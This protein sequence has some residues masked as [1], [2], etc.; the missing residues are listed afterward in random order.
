MLVSLNWLS[1]FCELPTPSQL[2][3]DFNR[4]GFEI[5]SDET[6][7]KG[8]T[9][10][11]V[12]HIL[13]FKNHPDADRLRI[14]SVDIGTDTVQIVTAA[15]NVNTGDKIPVSLPGA[16]LANGMK[17]KKGKLRG[18]ESNGM[19]CSAVECGLTDTSPGVWVLPENTPVGV[20]FIKEA[21]L[22]DTILDIAILPNRGDALS[23]IGLARECQALYGTNKAVKFDPKYSSKGKQSS[24]TCQV[25]QTICSYYRAQK[26]SG[27]LNKTTP[28]QYQTRLYYSG[29]KP[30]TW[31]VDVTNIVMIE[32]GQPLH[33]FDA[34]GVN[35][36]NVTKANNE[37]V[38]LLNEKEYKLSPNVSVVKVNQSIAAIAGIM[39]ARQYEVSEL[40]TAI[41]L[42][43]AIFDAV[44]VRQGTKALGVRSESSARFEK[45][46]DPSGL[47]LA[48]ARVLQLLSMH[49]NIEINQEIVVGQPL[50]LSAQIDVDIVKLNQFLG[51]NYGFSDLKKQ[52]TPLGFKVNKAQVTVPSWRA[53]DCQEWPDIAEEMCRFSGIEDI[54]PKAIESNIEINHDDVWIKR[55]QFQTAAIH[56]GLTEVIPFPLNEKDRIPNQPLILNPI[57]PELTELRS[58]A[59]SSLLNIAAVN[60][61]R[62]QRPCRLFTIGPAWDQKGTEYCH[63]SALLQGSSHFEPHLETHKTSVDF[64]QMKGIL[65]Q[66]LGGVKYDL[67]ASTEEILH[68]G[69]SADMIIKGTKVGFFGMLHPTLQKQQRIDKSAVLEFNVS[70]VPMEIRNYDL[71][72]KFPATTRDVTYI[73]PADQQV[74]DIIDILFANKPTICDSIV[75]CGYYKKDTEVNVSFRMIYQSPERSLEMAEV[76]QTHQTFAEAVIKKLPC[77]FP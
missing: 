25:D 1:E 62:H 68:P 27:V 67:V 6:K 48:V 44:D 60:A 63:F 26:I 12:G 40:S 17:I 35:E 54:I 47:Q 71:I 10:I 32:T 5:E 33:A 31:L 42:E 59:V 24:I 73:M 75:L 66:L 9:K 77:R 64:Y 11:V 49:D 45:S 57:S 8:L 39:G 22:K 56:L 46:V 34:D 38:Q 18:V 37:T 61:S 14:A 13:E 50:T 36:I 55:Q 30:K 19:M 29:F 74:Q 69:Q 21:Q 7:G 2:V 65:D 3:E 41:I 20:D 53:N 4:I 70:E 15:E 16:I 72:T 58:N 23:L 52:L 28:L 51:T 43:S 76:N